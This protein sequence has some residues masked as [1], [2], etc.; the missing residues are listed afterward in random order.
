MLLSQL[1]CCSRSVRTC[2]NTI[3]RFLRK[4][5]HAAFQIYDSRC[6]CGGCLH[7]RVIYG[8]RVEVH[9][10][11][12]CQHCTL[13]ALPDLHS[14]FP[15]FGPEKML[16]LWWCCTDYTKT[17]IVLFACMLSQL[18]PLLNRHILCAPVRLFFALTPLWL[19]IT[20]LNSLLTLPLQDQSHSH[21]DACCSSIGP[22][23]VPAAVVLCL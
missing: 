22:V 5:L 1:K 18:A 2:T 20:R 9:L 13:F 23:N 14:T 21:S 15:P 3:R 16:M 7:P 17:Y 10:S 6:S 11:V 19:V 8:Q 12:I 4:S